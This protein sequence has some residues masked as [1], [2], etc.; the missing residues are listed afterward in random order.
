MNLSILLH[1]I[2]PWPAEYPILITGIADDSR[3]VSPGDLFIAHA[4]PKAEH[5]RFIEQAIQQ[6]AVAVLREAAD[7]APSFELIQNIPVFSIPRLREQ[8]PTIA[9]RFYQNPT[10]H[11][12][13]VGVT[14]T[15]G[16]TSCSLFI[17]HVLTKCERRC[18]LIGTLGEG[19]PGSITPGTLTTPGAI[20]LQRSFAALLKDGATHV[21]MEV[22][23]HSLVQHRVA[24]VP[25][26]VAIFTNLTRDHLD[27]HGDMYHY[28]QAKRLLFLTPGL[29]HAVINADDAFGR[30]LLTEFRSQL[31]CTAYS[32][33]GE[34][35]GVP[36]VYV[37]NLELHS[38]GFSAHIYS[39]WGE[40]EL[41]SKLLGRFNV[42][43]VL[44]ALTTLC[45]LGLPFATVLEELAL[46]PSV[47]G[48]MQ[49]LGGGD[50]PL[51]VVD[52][53]HTPDALEKALTALREHTKGRLWCVFGCGGNRDAGKRP[54][55]AQ[56]AESHSDQVVI[57]DDNPRFENP[58]TI[59]KEI[60]G[61]IK[62]KEAVVVEPD[63]RQAIR[64]ALT[65]AQVGD[66]V[67]IAGKGH[68]TY[69]QIGEEKRH[70]SDVEEVE[71]QL[72]HYE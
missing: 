61:G 29:K 70:F 24:G 35:A 4:G 36:T 51:A 34:L 14:G 9:S 60:L 49:C 53:A 65:H 3:K 39:P 18:G 66:A 31:S 69:Q 45:V 10:E 11:L 64:Y 25:F 26:E 54:L 52:Y 17:A 40:G 16:K 56:V 8:L 1:H 72:C 43:N 37:E 38:H 63:R 7:G 19:F 48:R 15:N 50:K 13:F 27:Y 47:P 28:G 46:L 22:S 67:L 5:H 21:A 58:E 68:E 59:I 33:E 12:K 20:D 6:G 44:A 32:L 23:S 41:H 2:T 57:T 55:M 30:E 71:K 62:N 42:A